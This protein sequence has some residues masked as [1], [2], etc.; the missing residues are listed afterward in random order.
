M[1]VKFAIWLLTILEF[2]FMYPDED[3]EMGFEYLGIV[4]F[5]TGV[6]LHKWGDFKLIFSC[7]LFDYGQ[8]DIKCYNKILNKTKG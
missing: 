8:G 7:Y 5:G 3:D 6:H 4:I 2:S 1:K